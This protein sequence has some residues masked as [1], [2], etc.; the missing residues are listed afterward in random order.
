MMRAGERRLTA[1]DRVWYALVFLFLLFVLF[2]L[3]DR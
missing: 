1:G 3:G 2:F